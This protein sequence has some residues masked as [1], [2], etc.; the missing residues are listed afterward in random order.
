M[1]KSWIFFPNLSN[2]LLPCKKKITPVQ[3]QWPWLIAENEQE[4]RSESRRRGERRERYSHYTGLCNL[5]RSV[6]VCV[7]FASMQCHGSNRHTEPNWV[8]KGILCVCVC[9]FACECADSFVCVCQLILSL[10]LS[11]SLC[12][13]FHTPPLLHNSCLYFSEH[14]TRVDFLCASIIVLILIIKP[15]TTVSIKS[16]HVAVKQS[17]RIKTIVLRLPSWIG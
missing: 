5:Q 7:G 1:I 9:T 6:F 15:V 17:D 3:W 10:S 13:T 2:H 4:R 14:N 12:L 11:L 16:F 8:R